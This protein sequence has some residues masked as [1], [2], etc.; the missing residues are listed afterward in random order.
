LN[1]V[2]ALVIGALFGTGVFLLL[3][4]DLFRVVV[5]LVLISNAA[6]LTLMAS[7]LDRGQAPIQPAKGDE[8]V[9]DPLVQAMTLTALV[10]GFAVTA[11][12]LALSY[13]VYRSRHSVDLDELSA[14]EARQA[15]EDEE[16]EAAHDEE[17][18]LEEPQEHEREHDPTGVSR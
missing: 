2:F 12:L 9:A 8:A 16:R 5:G 17:R 10:I 3:K 7:G 15:A 13:A 18:E 4:T 11:L 1:L 14:Q 6:N